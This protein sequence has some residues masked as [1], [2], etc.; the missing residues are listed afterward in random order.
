[1]ACW[2]FSLGLSRF[3][4]CPGIGLGVAAAGLKRGTDVVIVGWSAEKLKAAERT[5]SSDG[6]VISLVADMTNEVDVAH[7]FDDVGAFDH[8]VST[9]GTLP[10]GDPIGRSDISGD[11]AVA[12]GTAVTIPSSGF[13][14]LRCMT[15]MIVPRPQG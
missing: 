6:R 11:G 5:L 9:A 10:P 13:F 1:V 2:S 15:M 4:S 8:L 3:L 12:A 14:C 7:M